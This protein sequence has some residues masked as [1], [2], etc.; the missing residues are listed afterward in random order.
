MNAIEL[1]NE[2]KR[3]L[4][5]NSTDLVCVKEA[6][7]ML[8]QQEM[9]IK[10]LKEIV[11]GT[12]KQAFYEDDYYKL[13]AEYDLLK[14]DLEVKKAIELVKILKENPDFITSLQNRIEE[15]EK[16]IE[17]QAE[18]ISSLKKQINL[19]G[20]SREPKIGDRV[21]LLDDESE[22][23]IE[24]LSI[25]GYPRINF[26]D[27]CYGNYTRIELITLFAYKESE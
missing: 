1:A 20:V 5:D 19:L 7:E 3:C 12:I 17:K 25:N 11:E 10:K 18:E 14:A 23:V 8:L 21:I 13:K 2:L 22:G 26:D 27:G 9:E 4:D 6:A 16:E 24:S 15:Q